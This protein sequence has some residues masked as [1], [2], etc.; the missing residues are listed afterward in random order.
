MH[1]HLLG[2]V[3]TT[4]ASCIVVEAAGQ[5]VLVDAGTTG[6]TN[7]IGL[8]A[9]IQA[10]G[11]L[12][13]A[14]VTHAHMDHA[15][16]LPQV[17][18]PYPRASLIATPATLAFLQVLLTDPESLPQRA[19][20]SAASPEI[21]HE[22]VQAV[23]ARG[24][25][26]LFR[27]RYSLLSR[28]SSLGQDWWLTLFRAGHV[29]GAAMVFL[30]TPEGTVL[31]SGDISLLRQQTVSA[32]RFSRQHNVDVLVLES[33]FGDRGYRS[34]EAEEARIVGQVRRALDRSGH[35]L[36]ACLGR[37]CR[38]RD[39]ADPC[40]CPQAQGGATADLGR[41]YHPSREYRLCQVRTP[42]IHRPGP[43]YSRV[44]QS[45]CTASRFSAS[46]NQPGRAG[47]AA[48]RTAFNHRQFLS[49]SPNGPKRLLCVS[50]GT[51]RRPLDISTGST[52]PGCHD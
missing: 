6:A 30:E 43:V 24:T 38:A 33:T 46:H 40:C 37:W 20:S 11:G 27:Q 35:V 12:D 51:G 28:T 22:K 25:P 10:L 16:A 23:L 15:G 17:L 45:F 34:R 36:I 9:Q 52:E 44:W 7:P 13:A 3:D 4:G 19:R 14:V 21:S 29:L 8:A 2:G 32:A 50:A 47:G 18:A 39:P 48:R 26:L 49:K 31:I 5:R 1:I 41:R 42:G